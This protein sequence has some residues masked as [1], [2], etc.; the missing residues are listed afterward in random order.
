MRQLTFICMLV[1]LAGCE[2]SG[3]RL[4]VPVPTA[5]R[6]VAMELTCL[7][8]TSVRDIVVGGYL[9]DV[10]GGIEGIL[11]RTTDGGERW[12]RIGSMTYDF[13][14]LLPQDIFFTDLRSGWVGGIRVRRGET[15][16]VVLRT[17]DGGGH[18]RDCEIAENRSS[19][20]L[21]VGEIAFSSDLAGSVSVTV[22]D[23][24]GGGVVTNVY[25]TRDGGKTFAI[26][27]FK[28]EGSGQQGD[29]ARSFISMKEGFRLLRPLENGTQILELTVDGGET[30]VAASQFQLGQF[31]Q[32]Y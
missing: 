5:D 18:F 6:F 17:D 8:A 25:D 12:R 20:V 16:P 13:V 10:D 4:E 7:H 15:I 22:E 32:Y 11:L 30:W 31:A 21:Q 23:A 24:A 29:P 27:E 1:V 2:S 3:D 14:G 26:G 28:A 9:T 19:V